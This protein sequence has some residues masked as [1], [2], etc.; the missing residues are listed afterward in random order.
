MS[1]KL[2]LYGLTGLL[3]LGCFRF[4][5][6]R[7]EHKDL[8]N[9]E[10][11]SQISSVKGQ[12]YSSLFLGR[13]GEGNT[14]PLFYS[15][16]KVICDI[17]QYKTPDLWHHQNAFD[18]LILRLN[19]VFFMSGA[20]ACIFFYFSRF[21]SLWAGLYSLFIALSS[22]MVWEHWVE[23]RPYS[24]WIFLTTLQSL[25][26]LYLVR[27]EKI[28]R[29]AWSGLTI[30]HFLLSLT[31]VFSVAQI[32]IV[33]GLLWVMKERHWKKYIL[34]ALIPSAIAIF[35]YTQ[36]PK[37]QF[38]FDLTPEQ[39]I[40]DCFSRD[41]FYILFIFIFFLGGRYVARKT[42]ISKSFPDKIILQGAACFSLTA[43]MLLAAFCVLAILKLT[44]T[45]MQGFPISSRYFVYLTPVSI[46][47]TTLLSMTVFRSLAGNRWVQTL[48]LG[49]M[50]YLIIHRFFKMLPHIKNICAPI[51]S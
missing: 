4:G 9:D 24:L 30:V 48:I 14:C 51:F 45:P 37:Y 22:F 38:Y 25:Y 33:S 43:L 1:R 10:I 42:G 8:W 23:A 18:R 7:A 15:I 29:R 50:G 6:L 28:S 19:P 16:Q 13:V 17:G 36:A 20:I 34:T 31:I 32:A 11:Y 5:L 12:S 21:Y 26:F 46:I 40:R 3:F 35:Y 41:R 2:L 39:L 27:C 47:S 44:S 49:G